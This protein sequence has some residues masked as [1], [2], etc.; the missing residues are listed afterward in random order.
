[1]HYEKAIVRP[2]C[3]NFDQGI[4]SAKLGAPDLNLALKQHH[5]Y[6][7]ALE[8]CGVSLAILEANPAFP[9]S[10]FVEDTAVL[11]STQA[12]LT[13]PGA[14][15]RRGEVPGIELVLAEHFE[16]LDSI[17]PPGTVDGGDVC[18]VDNHYFIGISGRT[19][20]DGAQQLASFL[21]REGYSSSFVN[22][23]RAGRLLHLKSGLAYLGDRRLVMMRELEG[24]AS[25]NGYEVIYVDQDEGYAANCVKVN[26]FVLVAAGY[27]K[28]AVRL[29]NLDYQVLTVD[30][31]EFQKMDGGLSCLSL[32]F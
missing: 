14:K 22:L 16:S 4:T 29:T 6:C 8:T 1:M 25:F 28:I 26:D 31:S 21:V 24:L 15:T 19:N 12:I 11:T 20:A 9:D 32:R 18:Q 7:K 2:P 10:T 23:D 13:R 5:S 3:I 27:P 17:Q 30:V